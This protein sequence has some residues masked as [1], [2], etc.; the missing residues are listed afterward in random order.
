MYLIAYCI[1]LLIETVY[2][3]WL[4]GLIILQLI[5][6]L[7][8]CVGLVFSIYKYKDSFTRFWLKLFLLAIQTYLLL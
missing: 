2:E 3:I 8:G 6:R 7:L 1:L 5:L 4:V